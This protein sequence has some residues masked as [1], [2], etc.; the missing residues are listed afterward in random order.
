MEETNCPL[1]LEVRSTGQT[2]R[3]HIIASRKFLI[4]RDLKI[5]SLLM[6]TFLEGAYL[7]QRSVC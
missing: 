3:S 4:D 6:C 7:S 1:T 2:W 5:Y